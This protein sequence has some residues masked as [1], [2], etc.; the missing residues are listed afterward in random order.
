MRRVHEPG[1]REETRGASSAGA[2][3]SLAAIALASALLAGCNDGSD[4]AASATPNF[5]VE[6]FEGTCRASA[7]E[8]GANPTAITV[9]PSLP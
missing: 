5:P 8:G 2:R 6:V 3:R 9:A 4:G 1:R 7:C